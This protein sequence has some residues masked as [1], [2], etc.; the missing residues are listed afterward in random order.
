MHE[1]KSIINISSLIP[2]LS[3]LRRKTASRFTLIEL[4]VVIAII[5]ILAGMLLPAL[6][7]AK[8]TA[9]TVQC[10]N[11]IKQIGTG[12]ILYHDTFN[13]FPPTT[14][15]AANPSG[16]KDKWLGMLHELAKIKPQNV[17]CPSFPFDKRWGLETAVEKQHVRNLETKSTLLVD[18][19]TWSFSDYG[20]NFL[21]MSNQKLSQFKQPSFTIATAETRNGLFNKGQHTVHSFTWV[22]TA[23]YFYVYPNHSGKANLLYVDGHAATIHG[24]G[25]G[26]TWIRSVYAQGGPAT[27]TN[28]TPNRWGLDPNTKYR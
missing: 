3:Y 28:M 26:E 27:G 5:A 16:R 24:T 18:A 21:Y 6:N 8:E 14:G 19:D 9:R 23:S 15:A 1:S 11:N 17:L 12:L 25:T 22:F 10:L 13:R 20:Y 7:Q 4:L 2:H